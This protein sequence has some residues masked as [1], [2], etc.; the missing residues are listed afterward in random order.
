[1]T[2]RLSHDAEGPLH[3]ADVMSKRKCF[4]WFVF[5]ALQESIKHTKR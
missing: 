1:M 5:G 3:F 4:H 2:T